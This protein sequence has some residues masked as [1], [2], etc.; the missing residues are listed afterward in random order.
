VSRLEV[1]AVDLYLVHSPCRLLTLS[2]IPTLA[3]ALAAAAESGLAR[4]V[5]VSNYSAGEVEETRRVL[6]ERGVPLAANQ[7]EFSLLHALPERSGLLDAC[8]D[9]GVG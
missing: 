6:A 2:S 8:A 1:E 3:R 4:H 7:V 5:G 9:M